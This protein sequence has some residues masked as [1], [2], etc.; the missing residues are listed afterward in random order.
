MRTGRKP[1]LLVLLIFVIPIVFLLVQ[2]VAFGW[3]WPD[4][5]P[6]QFSLRGW[7]AVFRDPNIA[8]ALQTSVVI[9]ASVVGLNLL[10][11]YPAGKALAWYS[12]RG[13]SLIESFLLLPILIPALAVAMGLQLTMI[14]L[15]LADR[16]AGV[17]VVH[18]LPTLPYSLRIMR[19]GYERLGTLWVDQARALGASSRTIFYT[20]SL[21]VLLPSIRSLILLSFVISLSQYALTAIIGGGMVTTLPIIYYPFFHSSDAAVMAAF[22]IVFALVPVVFMALVEIV[23]RLIVWYKKKV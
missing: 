4:I 16:M 20:I 2:S 5:V 14:R 15:G 3:R 23:I 1:F 12:F 21:P 17:I 7:R 13:K 6:D 19:A 10:L 18:L 11:A 9:G 8:A 22:S